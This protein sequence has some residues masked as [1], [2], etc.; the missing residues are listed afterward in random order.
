MRR[1]R[2]HDPRARPDESGV[3]EPAV[4]GE[5]L[6]DLHR[7]RI[8]DVH[9]GELR[10]RAPGQVRRGAERARDGGDR[11]RKRNG[12]RDLV[13]DH[14]QPVAVEEELRAG[15]ALPEA[16]C[17][18]DTRH[19]ARDR[20][21][22]ERVPRD[23]E[24]RGAVRLHDVGLV[25]ALLLV[26]RR[27]IGGRGRG[28]GVGGGADHP[29]RRRRRRGGLGC[30]GRA[31]HGRLGDR[32]L[33]EPVRAG[34]IG[35]RIAHERDARGERARLHRGS[36]RRFEGPGPAGRSKCSN[37]HRTGERGTPPP[38]GGQPT[39][40][41]SGWGGPGL[42]GLGPPQPWREALPARQCRCLGDQILRLIDLALRQVG[43]IGRPLNAASFSSF[44]ICV[45]SVSRCVVRSWIWF[46]T[47]VVDRV[48]GRFEREG[49]RLE[50]RRA[51]VPNGALTRSSSCS[52]V[53]TSLASR[54]RSS[55]SAHVASPGRVSAWTS[56][57]PSSVVVVLRAR[58]APGSSAGRS[59]DR[60]RWS[61][62]R[63][64]SAT[65]G[66]TKPT[67]VLPISDWIV[68]VV[69]REA[70]LAHWSPTGH[71]VLPAADFCEEEVVVAEVDERRCPVRDRC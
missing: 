1:R 10:G 8:G 44:L 9:L 11:P 7:R 64:C 12:V 67:Q 57:W 54:C 29:R 50:R 16:E 20:D 23:R 36:R 55:S 37:H 30:D 3:H 32:R 39:P 6:G 43:M 15:A 40:A 5:R 46:S 53:P 47:D 71:R 27:R 59:C 62:R 28:A 14:E 21:G 18:G 58:S 25:D 35:L 2:D 24:D 4:H 33:R 66:P 41:R 65:P 13:R 45:A 70:G 52:S 69:P 60:S 38:H 49:R 31:R 22:L 61:S 63:R 19:P 34:E 56:T 42:E 51:N 17:A 68:A 26:V 48:V